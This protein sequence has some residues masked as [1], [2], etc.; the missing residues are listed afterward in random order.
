MPAAACRCTAGS[1]A[2]TTN[3]PAT[4][5]GGADAKTVRRRR[6]P[7]GRA[8]ASARPDDV[9]PGVEQ[10]EARRGRRADACPLDDVAGRGAADRHRLEPMRCAGLRRR[11]RRGPGRRCADGDDACAAVER[12]R[13]PWRARTAPVAP[14]DHDDLLG[15]A[16]GDRRTPRPPRDR[17][18]APV[19][20]ARS[21]RAGGPNRTSR[22]TG[23]RRH[24]RPSA[25]V[26]RSAPHA[27]RRH[28]L[29]PRRGAARQ[30]RDR[31]RR[32][33][34]TPRRGPPAT[35]PRCSSTAPRTSH[36]LRDVPARRRA[37][38]TACCSPGL[39]MDAD[40]DLGDG[41]RLGGLL[42]ELLRRGVARQRPRVAVAPELHRGTQPRVRARRERGR[43]ATSGSTT[44]SAGS[45]ASTRR[46]SS[47][48]APSPGPTT[49]RSWAGSTSATAT[50]TT[51]RHHGDPHRADLSATNYGAAT[52]VA[53]P[54]GRAA[55]PGGAGRRLHLRRAVERPDPPR[56][57]G[58]VAPARPAPRSTS[59]PAGSSST[60]RGPR[61]PQPPSGPYAMQVVR[62][63][64]V[65]RRPFPF[66]PD[67]E[68][69]IARAYLHAFSRA[70]RL[71]YLE[72]QYLWSASAR[73]RARRRAVARARAAGRHRHPAVPRSGRLDLGAGERDRS[74]QRDAR[75]R[76]RRRPAGRG[77]RPGQRRRHPDLRALEG[78]HRR[79]R[80]ARHRLR[81][82]QPAVVEPR[83]R[84][85][86]HHRRARRAAR[87]TDA[88]GRR[89][90]SASPPSTSALDDPS[91]L[92]DPVGVV[93]RVLAR[94]RPRRSRGRTAAAP[95][96]DHP[97]GSGSTPPTA[98]GT[99]RTRCCASPTTSSSIPTAGPPRSARVDRY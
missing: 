28:R 94:R 10:A 4:R 36:C 66:A 26:R 88:R 6:P 77:L 27:P 51:P 86:L 96:P 3:V 17:A 53:R 85:L 25:S 30:P 90:G 2:T 87:D 60:C 78:V 12:G 50:T 83:L 65:H 42:V 21:R 97:G 81:Q 22:T 91:A 52:A 8:S 29:V 40:L 16:R 59:V 98:S 72:D 41:V 57:P 47:S 56:P 31:H 32:G 74:P 33:P 71:V 34:R 23:P 68:R 38:A 93:R 9:H 76:R 35:P 73:R 13:A 45:G 99:S 95:D 18:S 7:I 61:P 11:A 80:V 89:R 64:P 43:A 55:R 46:S 82:P 63:Y 69:S 92:L 67:G 14:N 37:P 44:A 79:R 75:A 20:T 62:T 24:R 39:E 19:A 58:A 49:S 48:A 5:S 84:D 1:G 70:R 15:D 54:P